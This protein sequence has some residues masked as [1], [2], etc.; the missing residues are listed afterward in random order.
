[1][2]GNY[3]TKGLLHSC[4]IMYKTHITFR[5]AKIRCLKKRER[6]RESEREEGRELT[7]IK[8]SYGPI[9]VPWYI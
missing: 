2:V 3:L 6:E 1:M 9:N 7:N 5:N 8:H 4:S